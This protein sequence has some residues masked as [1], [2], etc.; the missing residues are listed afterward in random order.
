[1]VNLLELAPSPNTSLSTSEKEV[2]SEVDIPVVAPKCFLADLCVETH[3]HELLDLV[4]LSDLLRKVL[5]P[6]LCSVLKHF[7][8]IFIHA[9]HF[10]I[11]WVIYI[12]NP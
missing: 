9:G 1:M 11:L 10:C 5:C 4:L 12:T 6:R 2:G 3:L 8:V 7:A